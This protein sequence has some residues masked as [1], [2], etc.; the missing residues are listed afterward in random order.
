MEI[1]DRIVYYFINYIVADTACCCALVFAAPIP[2]E[3]TG[4]AASLPHS[5][6]HDSL[7]DVSNVKD[8]S[9]K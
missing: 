9:A 4:P 7:L 3:I 2:Q 1:D 5:H 6:N 8:V